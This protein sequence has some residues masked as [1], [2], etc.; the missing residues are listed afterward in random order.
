MTQSEE[1][2]ARALHKLSTVPDRIAAIA[3]NKTLAQLQQPPAPNEWAAHQVLAHIRAVD[4]IV[5]SRIYMILTRDHSPL[6]DF[7]ERRWAEIADY[8]HLDFRRSLTFFALRQQEV[9]QTLR[10]LPADAWQRTGQHEVRGTLSLL[11]IV[12]DLA[13]HLEEHCLQIENLFT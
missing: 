5:T 2:I 4:A 11:D 13:N 1:T 10:Q 7:D 3:A 9:V 6:I 8:V 12:E